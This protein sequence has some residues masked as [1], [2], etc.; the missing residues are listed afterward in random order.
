VIGRHRLR[1][2]G[3]SLTDVTYATLAGASSGTTAPVTNGHS[4]RDSAQ[5]LLPVPVTVTTA[6]SAPVGGAPVTP[7]GADADIRP[8]AKTGCDLCA[9]AHRRAAWK[10]TPPTAMS[11]V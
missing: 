5:D 10:P 9:E 11:G 7:R 2:Q 4:L 6:R 1:Q 8:P 3:C